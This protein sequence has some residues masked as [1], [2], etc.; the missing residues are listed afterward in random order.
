DVLR[1][2]IGDKIVTVDGT[3]IE[4]EVALSEFGKDN[5]SGRIIGRNAASR[6]SKINLTLA[7]A[8]PKS[9]KMDTIIRMGTELGIKQLIPV[10]TERVIVQG[11]FEHKLARWRRIAVE[12][13][14][15]SGRTI[16]PEVAD[17][18]KYEDV[19]KNIKKWQLA[20]IPW[21]VHRGEGLK[22][23]VKDSSVRDVIIFIGPE[24]GFSHEEVRLAEDAGVIPVTLGARI[25]R[26]DTAAV[27]SIS[28]V[29]QAFNE[30]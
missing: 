7:Q 12:S 20:L 16:I 3:G 6:E 28:L 5:I 24:G 29:M 10:I 30:I 22:T 21:E 13:C 1:L 4:Y 18:A 15:Q 25:L 14:K 27:T 9:D 19:L 2:K 23:A 11:N 17:A 8:V 26:V